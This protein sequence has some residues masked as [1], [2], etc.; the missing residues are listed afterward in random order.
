MDEKGIVVGVDLSGWGAFGP[1]N[2]YERSDN[3]GIV[4]DA[5]EWRA[6]GMAWGI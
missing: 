1:C 3:G 6:G 5:L 2:D 4:W